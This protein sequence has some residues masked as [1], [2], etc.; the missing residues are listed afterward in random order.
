MA[1]AAQRAKQA[2]EKAAREA[3]QSAPEQTPA[4]EQ[5]ATAAL[6]TSQANA[7]KTAE[8][9]RRTVTNPFSFRIVD[10]NVFL[11]V[12]SVTGEATVVVGRIEDKGAGKFVVTRE[13]VS[14]SKEGSAQT[15]RADAVYYGVR[16]LLSRAA[17]RDIDPASRES[18]STA[19]LVAEQQTKRADVAEMRAATL[20]A[21]MKGDM[22]GITLEMAQTL[23][24]ALVAA[25]PADK[26]ELYASVK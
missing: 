8:Q 4:P 11:D 7:G 12:A 26:Q 19:K 10:G 15:G 2:A 24:P 16:N 1:T 18:V 3:A 20:A 23:D 25:L 14:L 22:S 21:L 6:V 13:G 17:T 9:K 5:A